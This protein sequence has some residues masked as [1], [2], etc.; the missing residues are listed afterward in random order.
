[1]R[2]RGIHRAWVSQGKSPALTVAAKETRI[3]VA[4]GHHAYHFAVL[5]SDARRAELFENWQRARNREA[6][7]WIEPLA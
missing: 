1:M 2:S 7:K 4:T 6:L 3:G 5:W